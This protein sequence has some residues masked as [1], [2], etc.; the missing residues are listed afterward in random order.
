ML[1]TAKSKYLIGLNGLG[2]I[3]LEIFKLLFGHV[4]LIWS[5]VFLGLVLVIGLILLF[6]TEE[7]LIRQDAEKDPDPIPVQ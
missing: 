1:I 5:C 2:V 3:V 4:G 7:K 6:F